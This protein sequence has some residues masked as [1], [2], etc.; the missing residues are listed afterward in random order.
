MDSSILSVD[1]QSL[2]ELGVEHDFRALE[3]LFAQLDDLLVGQFNIDLI[4]LALLLIVKFSD[5]VLCNLAVLLLDLLDEF[6]FVGLVEL[7][8]CCV[9]DQAAQ[10]LSH[11]TSSNGVLADGDLVDVSIDDGDCM[12]HTVTHVQNGSSG[13]SCGEEGKHSLD[14]Y[15]EA[16][17]FEVL[18]EYFSH[19]LLVLL[20]V[21][22]WLSL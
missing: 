10:S 13:L 21:Q 16:G 18:K 1:G 2:S 6:L 12:A 11:C 8:L 5:W 9:T 3:Q 14:V 17:Y 19:L 22:W 15:V 20:G 7:D 4:L